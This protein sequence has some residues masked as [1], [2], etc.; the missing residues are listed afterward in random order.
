MKNKIIGIG[1][2]IA[3]FVTFIPAV[4]SLDTSRIKTSSSPLNELRNAFIFGRYS[5]LTGDEGVITVVTAN[6]FVIYK[7]PFSFAHFPR[8]TELTFGMYTSYGHIY[9]NIQFLLLH[10]EL[11]V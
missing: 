9:R 6:M 2:C 8:G 10:V 11:D 3:L 7:N 5:N 1:I 4:G